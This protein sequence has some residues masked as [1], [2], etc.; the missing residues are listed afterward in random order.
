MHTHTRARANTRAPQVCTHT[1][2]H[3]HTRTRNT[4][5]EWAH[6]HKALDRDAELLARELEA[7]KSSVAVLSSLVNA[8]PGTAAADRADEGDD[9]DDSHDGGTRS[10]DQDGEYTLLEQEILEAL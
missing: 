5:C 3:A 4:P 6:R 7:A 8:P 10:E 2:T 1:Y 9:F